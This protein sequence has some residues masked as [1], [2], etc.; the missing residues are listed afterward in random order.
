MQVRPAGLP[1]PT[2]YRQGRDQ[3]RVPFLLGH[4]GPARIVDTVGGG[5]A[6]LAPGDTW[7]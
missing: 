5:V 3:R 1:A 2:C 6:D 7:S 4:E